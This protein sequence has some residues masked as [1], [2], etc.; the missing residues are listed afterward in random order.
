[1]KSVHCDHNESL[2]KVKK[3]LSTLLSLCSNDQ[4]KMTENFL[5]L[6]SNI[7]LYTQEQEILLSKK[8]KKCFLNKKDIITEKFEPFKTKYI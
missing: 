8:V 3:W 4:K 7:T 6:F 1:M 2:I 5:T